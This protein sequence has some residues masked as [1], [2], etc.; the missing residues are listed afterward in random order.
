MWRR[1]KQVSFIL[2]AKDTVIIPD[3]YL[4]DESHVDS[5]FTD[6]YGEVVEQP[7][8]PANAEI[9]MTNRP[10]TAGT[11][12]TAQLQESYSSNQQAQSPEPTGPTGQQTFLA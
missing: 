2:T 11:L 12:R 3:D 5:P 4:I 9:S 6:K 8:T 1:Y 7:I 10:T